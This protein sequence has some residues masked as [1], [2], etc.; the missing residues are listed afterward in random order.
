MKRLQELEV[1][2]EESL[3]ELKYRVLFFCWFSLSKFAVQLVLHAYRFSVSSKLFPNVWQWHHVYN[4][5]THSNG[6]SKSTCGL[7]ERW[8][9]LTFYQFVRRRKPPSTSDQTKLS[10]KPG[11]KK[12]TFAVPSTT[13]DDQPPEPPPLTIKFKHTPITTAQV[14]SGLQPIFQ[15]VLIKLGRTQG[16]HQLHKSFI[17]CILIVTFVKTSVS[18]ANRLV[19]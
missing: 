9:W 3:Y 16:T 12:I 5:I 17:A 10:E 11:D 13:K 1:L 19:C 15:V 14:R 18:E 7:P 6:P 4:R 2:D 8:P